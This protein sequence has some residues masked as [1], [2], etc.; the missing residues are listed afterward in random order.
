[1]KK[2]QNPSG[3]LRDFLQEVLRKLTAF[4]EGWLTLQR[5]V[6]DELVH[7]K[8][9][10]INQIEKTYAMHSQTLMVVHARKY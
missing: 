9:P 1:M 7:S 5:G 6:V 8:D 3:T 2:P 4:E 10:L